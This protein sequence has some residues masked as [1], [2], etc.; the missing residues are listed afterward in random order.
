MDYELTRPFGWYGDDE[1]PE[2]FPVE[3]KP[4]HSGADEDTM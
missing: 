2:V 1:C 3:D 4:Y